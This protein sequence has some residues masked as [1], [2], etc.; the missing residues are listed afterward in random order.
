ME[1]LVSIYWVIFGLSLLPGLPLMIF[2]RSYV[3]LI[4]KNGRNKPT[5]IFSAISIPVGTAGVASA[6]TVLL[7]VISMWIASREFADFFEEW[8]WMFWLL[9][10]AVVVTSA[11]RLH[12]TYKKLSKY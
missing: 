9:Y 1:V 3:T 11:I 4:P 10:I 5:D 2:C 12:A 6:G 7:T 8:I